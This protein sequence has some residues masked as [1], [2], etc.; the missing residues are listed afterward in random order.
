MLL[1]SVGLLLGLL[2]VQA[3][4]APNELSCDFR[5]PCCW[6][7]LDPNTHW[8]AGY[9]VMVYVNER[10]VVNVNEPKRFG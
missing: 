10:A 6:Q 3:A 1:R 8:S 7:S 9:V 2:A 5:R 4:K